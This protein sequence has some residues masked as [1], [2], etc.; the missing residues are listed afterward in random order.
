MEVDH[1]LVRTGPVAAGRTH[2]IAL[3]EDILAVERVV[4]A[5]A[6]QDPSLVVAGPISRSSTQLLLALEQ[7]QVRIGL[8]FEVSE[9]SEGRQRKISTRFCAFSTGL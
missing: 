8:G 1:S 4:A 3:V 9:E 7:G 6:V 5:D 2:H